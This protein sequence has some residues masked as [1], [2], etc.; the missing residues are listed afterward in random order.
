M[1]V[2]YLNLTDEQK[3][4]VDNLIE[5]ACD[6]SEKETVLAKLD[7]TLEHLQKAIDLVYKYNGHPKDSRQHVGWGN[8]YQGLTE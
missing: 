6:R 5:Q 3:E 4:E 1:K 8:R 2:S 7:H